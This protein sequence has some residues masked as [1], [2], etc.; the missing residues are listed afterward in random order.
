LI[1][2]HILATTRRFSKNVD[3]MSRDYE[4]Y[5]VYCNHMRWRFTVENHGGRWS[6]KPD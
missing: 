4:S 3:A 1:A 2:S 6:L 5:S